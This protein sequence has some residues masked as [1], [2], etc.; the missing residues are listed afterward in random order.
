MRYSC[1]VCLILVCLVSLSRAEEYPFHSEQDIANAQSGELLVKTGVFEIGDERY[2]AD[3][4]TMIVPE[5]RNNKNSRLIHLPVVRICSRNT[6]PLE[7]IFLLTGGPGLSNIWQDPPEWLLVNHDI[8]MVG[9][10]GFDGS[11]F[12]EC[13][14]ASDAVQV[15]SAPL[16]SENIKKLGTALH[17]SYERLKSE[18]VDIDGYTMVE[19][20]DDIDNA[21]KKLGYEKANLYSI[22]Y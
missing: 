9:Y 11:V 4:C 19:V 12:L 16:S 6:E 17:K 1:L 8:V 20:A 13:P 14:E 15:A 18:G 22:S 2:D 3:Y 21:R 5:N 7:P 10:R